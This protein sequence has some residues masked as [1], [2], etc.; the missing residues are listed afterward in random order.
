MAD[1]CKLGLLETFSIQ[2]LSMCTDVESAAKQVSQNKIAV[3]YDVSF[4]AK[5]NISLS[6]VKR[7]LSATQADLYKFNDRLGKKIPLRDADAT[8]FGAGNLGLVLRSFNGAG[9][10]A[11]FVITSQ[12]TAFPLDTIYPFSPDTRVYL[13][14]PQAPPPYTMEFTSKLLQSGGDATDSFEE[15]V[16]LYARSDAYPEHIHLGPYFGVLATEG[17]IKPVLT[18]DE[19]VVTALLNKAQYLAYLKRTSM[20]VVGNIDEL[21][22]LNRFAGR[23]GIVTPY[24]SYL[25]LVNE[26]QR[27]LLE[28]LKENYDRYQEQAVRENLTWSPPPPIWRE[29]IRLQPANFQE[30]KSSGKFG[31]MMAQDTVSLSTNWSGGG[32]SG[33]I[34]SL[35]LILNVGLAAVGLPI[36][37][38][39][40]LRKKT[41]F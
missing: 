27:L 1:V 5:K 12:K 13:I 35:F 18:T 37:L 3:L 32:G 33:G 20:D 14:H 2:T 24:S 29:P 9:Y 7:V 40:V 25:A 41:N 8:Y 26:E 30:S 36:Y 16:R 39:K 21:D 10:N 38:I 17:G 11:V 15:A 23:A 28:Q 34:D 6:E 31:M 19:G 22:K 4:E